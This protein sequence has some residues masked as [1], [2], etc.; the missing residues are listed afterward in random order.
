MCITGVPAG[1]REK[2]SQGNANGHEN[3]S[4]KIMGSGAEQ[5][6]IGTEGRRAEPVLRKLVLPFTMRRKSGNCPLKRLRCHKAKPEK[7]ERREN[8]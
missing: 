6:C 4:G 8:R 7:G 2:E 5:R 3:E 1:I